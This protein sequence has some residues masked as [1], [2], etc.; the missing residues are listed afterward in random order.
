M[1][2]FFSKI[3]KKLNLKVII[4]AHPR[5]NYNNEFNPFQGRKIIFG[6]SI[7][8]VKKSYLVLTH[9]S[10]ANNFTV[11]YKKPVFFINSKKYSEYFSLTIET[12]SSE[13]D[14]RPIDIS[15]DYD[16][17]FNDALIDENIY[18]NYMEKY[19]KSSG[20]SLLTPNVL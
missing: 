11:A 5:S 8:L 20:S 15:S 19:I 4:S 17:D 14:K 2:N 6:E 7:N 18:Q 3:E 13:F 10:T 9:A 1:N 12:F 16:I